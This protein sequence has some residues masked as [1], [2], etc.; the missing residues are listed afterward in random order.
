MLIPKLLD[1]TR[2]SVVLLF[3]PKVNLHL[4]C[5]FEKYSFVDKIKFQPLTKFQVKPINLT[6]Y[7][8]KRK[9]YAFSLWINQPI[10]C[11]QLSQDISKTECSRVFF[12][13]EEKSI[14]SDLNSKSKSIHNGYFSGSTCKEIIKNDVLGPSKKKHVSNFKSSSK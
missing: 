4:N 6:Q 10:N 2:Y 11:S 3:C 5:P 14:P 13:H 9:I 8:A 12:N 7:M 1:I